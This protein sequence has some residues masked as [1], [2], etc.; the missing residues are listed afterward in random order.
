MQEAATPFSVGDRDRRQQQFGMGVCQQLCG[1]RVAGAI[2]HLV[3]GQPDPVRRL[4]ALEGPV[5]EQAREL[6]LHGL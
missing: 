5:A 2:Q 4:R 6:L 1:A 3:A